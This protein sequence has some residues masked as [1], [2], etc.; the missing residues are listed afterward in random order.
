MREIIIQPFTGVGEAIL[1]A[2]E[3]KILAVLGKPTI[4][5]EEYYGQ[6]KTEE[7]L[8]RIYEY[9]ALQLELSFSADDDFRLSTITVYST[10]ASI[11]GITLIGLQED[12]FIME[13]MKLGHGKP[14]IDDDWRD[15]KDYVIDSLGL[16][17]WISGDIVDNVT[18]FPQYDDTGN[19]PIWPQEIHR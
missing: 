10:N 4:I 13:A 9:E 8:S 2:S 16:S 5:K 19:I 14:L 3:E 15:Y 11:D 6:E 7:N 12:Q 17:F 1:G 18:I